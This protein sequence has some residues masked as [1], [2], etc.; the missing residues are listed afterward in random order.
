[1]RKNTQKHTSKVSKRK[2]TRLTNNEV[3]EQTDKRIL[4]HTQKQN[5]TRSRH[6]T[7][8]QKKTKQNIS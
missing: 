7:I 3:I 4:T 1:M 6:A 5:G 8:Q 2:K